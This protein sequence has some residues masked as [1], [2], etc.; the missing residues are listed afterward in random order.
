MKK[1]VFSSIFLW[2]AATMVFTANIQAQVIDMIDLRTTSV[3]G[4]PKLD[5]LQICSAAGDTL[6]IL[7][8]PS[9]AIT[10][11]SY[12]VNL[13]TGLLYT[14]GVSTDP[15]GVL[16]GENVG[17]TPEVPIFDLNDFSGD[18][19]IYIPIRANCDILALTNNSQPVN[20]EYVLDHDGGSESFTPASEYNTQIFTPAL[21]I[22][23]VNPDYPTLYGGQTIDRA[24]RI[25]QDGIKAKLESFTYQNNFRGGVIFNSIT[26]RGP[27]GTTG[28]VVIPVGSLNIVG[29]VVTVDITSTEL[30]AIGLGD[31]FDEGERM[32]VIENITATCDNQNSDFLASWGCDSAICEE[33]KRVNGF[34]LAIADPNLTA[35][36]VSNPNPPDVCAANNDVDITITNNG[37]EFSP[38][39]GYAKDVFVTI[40]SGCAGV[41]TPPMT[42]DEGS[43]Q[44]NGTP[45]VP[46]SAVDGVYTF[47]VAAL[48]DA[49][50]AVGG[51]TDEDGDGFEDDLALGAS[52]TVTLS[53]QLTCD[54]G[55]DCNSPGEFTCSGF[56]VDID[57]TDHC[58]NVQPTA[59]SNIAPI[60]D[61]Q[62]GEP[63]GIGQPDV[64]TT[65]GTSF[66]MSFCYDYE[67]SGVGCSAGASSVLQIS[68]AN[69]G[70]DPVSALINGAT[71]N[72]TAI[73]ETLIEIDGGTV[74]G[75][76]SD[77]WDI[78]LQY[79]GPDCSSFEELFDFEVIYDCPCCT[80]SAIRGCSSYETYFYSGC[81]PDCEGVA[82]T[83]MTIERSTFSYTD[84]SMSTL[85]SAAGGADVSRAL[86][87]DDVSWTIDLAVYGDASTAFTGAEVVVGFEPPADDFANNPFD[88]LDATLSH[89]GVL[90]GCSIS[91]PAP[92][93]TGGDVRYTFDLSACLGAEGIILAD[94]DVMQLIGNFNI[95]DVPGIGGNFTFLYPRGDANATDGAGTVFG[96]C[97]NYGG[98]NFYVAN[99][100]ITP[101]VVSMSQ[102]GCGNYVV[103]GIIA[104]NSSSGDD[105]PN[106]YRP[107][108]GSLSDLQFTVPTG[109]TFV[110]N[111]GQIEILGASATTITADPTSNGDNTIF[112]FSDVAT[113]P[114]KDI[115]GTQV[116]FTFQL[117]PNCASESGDIDFDMTINDEFLYAEPFEAACL[118]DNDYN[119][120][121]TFN[122]TNPTIL[123]NPLAPVRNATESAVSWEL[124]VCNL[125]SGDYEQVW[126]SFDNTSG[127][128]SYAYLYDITDSLQTGGSKEL[129]TSTNSFG[130]GNSIWAYLETAGNPMPLTPSE[131]RF[132][133]IEVTYT[134]C[135]ADQIDVRVGANCSNNL[136]DPDQG[137]T[138]GYTCTNESSSTLSFIP[139]ESGLQI[140]LLSQP[141]DPIPLCSN[142]TYEL[143]I[144]NTKTGAVYDI[145]FDITLPSEGIEFV[146]S[147]FEFSYP[148]DEVSPTAV[149]DPIYIE[150]NANGDVYRF[151][152]ND[153]SIN[154]DNENGLSG[155]DADDPDANR[156]FLRFDVETDCNYTSGGIIRF[157]GNGTDP[158]GEP[159]SSILQA[160]LPYFIE[161][162]PPYTLDPSIISSS[163]DLGACD[164][165]G[166]STLTASI[167]NEGPQIMDA[168]NSDSVII[169]LPADVIYDT[170]S[171]IIGEPTVTTVNANQQR[172]AF[173]LT[174][175]IGINQSY[176]FDFDVDVPETYGC[177]SD[178]ITMETLYYKIVVCVDD[179]SNCD[180]LVPTSV[181]ET[182]TINFVKPQL[183]LSGSV[184]SS[185]SGTLTNEQ[186]DAVININNTGGI[187][188][189]DNTN[190][191]F[192]ED[193]GNGTFD[194][195]ETV[196]ETF[197][198]ATIPQGNNTYNHS[199]NVPTSN[200]ACSMHM[201]I[202]G[203]TECMC[204][205]TDLVVDFPTIPYQ[206]AGLDVS[207]C[208]EGTTTLGC[209]DDVTGYT[210][211][212][213]EPVAGA[214][215]D[216]NAPNPD[217]I[218]EVLT[219]DANANN[220]N[221]GNVTY[222]FTLTTNRGGCTTSDDVV[223]TVYPRLNGTETLYECQ[224]N[225]AAINIVLN[226][227][228]HTPVGGTGWSWTP[229]AGNSTGGSLDASNIQSPTFS[230]SN[231][232]A[233]VYDLSYTSPDGCTATYQSTIVVP[234][235]PVIAAGSEAEICLPQTSYQFAATISVGTGTWSKV[236]GPDPVS[237]DDVNS[238][239]ATVSG[240][241]DGYCYVYR[242]TAVNGTDGDGNDV[243]TVTDDIQICLMT[244]PDAGSDQNVCGTS[245]TLAGNAVNAATG[246]VGTWSQ[247][248]GPTIVSF[249]PDIN[250]PTT[251]ISNMIATDTGIEYVLRWTIENS[252]CTDSSEVT[253]TAFEEPTISAGADQELCGV[254][255]T[256][257]TGTTSA[258]TGTW[259]IANN[260][261]DA[262]VAI[263]ASG[264]ITNMDEG[265]CYT[266]TWTVNNTCI[267]TDDVQV[268]VIDNPNAG[269]DQNICATTA[270]LTA[271]NP[272]VGNGQWYISSNS[273]ASDAIFNPLDPNTGV[274]NLQGGLTYEF[275][276]EISNGTC[277][278]RDTMQI[279]VDASPLTVSAGNDQ[280]LCNQAT[281][282]VIGTNSLGT[283]AWSVSDN[284]G[285]AGVAIDASGN[286]INMDAGNC[287]TFLWTVTNGTCVAT[288]EVQVCIDEAPTPVNAGA[289]QDVCSNSTQLSATAPTIGVGEW[290]FTGGTGIPRPRCIV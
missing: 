122:H 69:T 201:V 2:C 224:G 119:L 10:G 270:Q 227:Q 31:T 185:C 210:Y 105:F 163:A 246:E 30:A 217:I 193:D 167:F 256:T 84:V 239:T 178:E 20:I 11:A 100:E 177:T 110:A 254:T 165:N 194:G 273:D 61:Y 25:S 289:D 21:N 251:T 85:A 222:T 243:C 71:A 174:G 198:I 237:F 234:E 136:I 152:L 161:G 157:S 130:A 269:A 260:G 283:G 37:V 126:M 285:D 220:S 204:T 129:I 184:V 138:G 49:G 250:T 38:G 113:I 97:D 226:N 120:T 248:S 149:I 240:M 46:T 1:I 288:D 34:N 42:V 238:P 55:A 44:F 232:G 171:S 6:S 9:A 24:I 128:I 65:P 13:P 39:A 267:V 274:A 223:I 186:I 89:N 229:D 159:S 131:C 162:S 18:F 215:S 247:V 86:T 140:N 106:E 154:L 230:T 241:Q 199:F 281:A 36:S 52:L 58:D 179:G 139:Q 176:T 170:G 107:Y 286:I 96:D 43:F 253:I 214:L 233:F 278:D 191:I 87:C 169:T 82:I 211:T 218:A 244:D 190:V 282:T 290:S 94:G 27:I 203:S 32:R 261:G 271:N 195:T 133:E 104:N 4:I 145:E 219:N 19:N 156:A 115:A 112:T 249:S 15:V 262:D 17:S 63:L 268:C 59:S 150:T 207:I 103:T 124:Q 245:T 183:T 7:V 259:S 23:T 50:A 264:N 118:S 75:A 166:T 280:Q 151:Q 41:N 117:A 272:A 182:L 265:T 255:T 197:T 137:Y 158:C 188:K 231:F 209:G 200:D 144:K 3:A 35:T 108:F 64:V 216:I 252:V 135:T 5:S 236:S 114:D 98:E 192:Y 109:Y 284:A 16:S 263:D 72:I 74:D 79:N 88:F 127:T 45:I 266:F 123:L 279:I 83:D 228:G 206:N 148:Y 125:G 102:D 160:S 73:S 147:S 287:Y 153:I 28:S 142:E 202:L 92:T 275:V 242:W 155:V 225:G 56:D 175:S 258:S 29:D 173:L 277:T 26:L 47:D 12:T 189:E 40:T 143:E 57:Y 90:T 80:G 54:G 205:P 51:L 77:C 95:L 66:T 22:L 141:P 48:T 70:I 101:S 132:Y 235:R 181:V 8:S 134:N 68:Y 33:V 257:L 208:Q 60:L 164:A 221:P 76:I 212:W 78:T 67:L 116:E 276:W 62:T 180:I 99:P 196:L 213:T 168:I 111:S 146:T 172:L 93:F 121:G 187:E 14:S 81:G 53:Y 91:V